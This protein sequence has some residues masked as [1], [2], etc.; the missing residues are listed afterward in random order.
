[1]VKFYIWQYI[2]FSLGNFVLEKS[3]ICIS[4]AHFIFWVQFCL[5]VLFS[6]WAILC[7]GNLK[8]LFWGQI[9][10]FM[11]IFKV[12]EGA[13]LFKGLQGAKVLNFEVITLKLG[14]FKKNI[15]V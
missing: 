13:F 14:Q 11:G 12:Y 6:I 3:K 4:G 2:V 9:F 7:M 15:W 8:Y 10:L 5:G 1:M